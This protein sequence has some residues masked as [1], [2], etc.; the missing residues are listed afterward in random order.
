MISLADLLRARDALIQEQQAIISAQAARIEAL[1]A[2]NAQLRA[3]VAQLVVRVDD[4]EA[5]LKGGGRGGKGS[6]PTRKPSGK[7]RGGQQ[8]HKGHGRAVP[9]QPDETR[10]H[11]L[12]ACPSC[13]GPVVVCDKPD[14]HWQFEAVERALRA[15]LHRVH[16]GWCPHCKKSVRAATPGVLARTLY[17]PRAHVTLASLRATMGATVGDLE[18][19]ARTVWQRS[20]AGGQIVAMLDRVTVALLDTFWWM[21]AQL[22]TLPAVYADSTGWVVDGERAVLWVFTSRRLTVYWIDPSGGGR[23][24]RQVVGPTMQ[25]HPVTDGAPR[26]QCVEHAREQRCLAH[27]LRR[28]RDL[29]L[30]HPDNEEMQ[31]MMGAL[32]AHLSWMIGLHDRRDDLSPSTWLQYRARARRVL[33]EIARGAWTDADCVRM[34]KRIEREVDLWVTFLWEES[35]EVEPTNNRAERD[36]RPGVIDRKR[37]QQNRSLRGIFREMVLRSV[38]KTCVNLGLS[39]EKVAIDAMLRHERMGPEAGPSPMLV[40]AFHAM[41]K[42]ETP[43]KSARAQPAT[44]EN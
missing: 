20:I 13:R 25:G 4:L 37:M 39:F 7:P 10:E 19:Y 18:T 14:E 6:P 38:A 30:A 43:E 34:S 22:S 1:E 17:G 29:L 21:V 35:G 31:R 8:G 27:P 3:L 15:V 16:K 5:M 24:V 36:L 44:H 32:K 9:A 26:F 2:E 42:P 12:T 33:L 11:P 41:A 23:V 40:E 28:A